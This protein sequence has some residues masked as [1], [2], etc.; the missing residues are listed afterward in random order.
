MSLSA[1]YVARRFEPVREVFER[2]FEEDLEL[3]AGF[4]AWLGDEL[5]VNLTG[6]FA[7][8]ERTQAWTDRTLC[9]VFSTTKP[10]AAL[11]VA[12]LADRGRIDYDAPLARYWPEFGANGKADA[13]VAEALSH[14]AGVPGF[15][16]A[17]DPDLWLDPPALAAA[18]ARVA[19]MWSRGTGSGY[20]PLTWG[21]IAGEL[22]RS[23]DGRS[24]GRVLREE[25]CVP[26]GLDFWIGTPDSE[27]DRAA[28]MMKPRSPTAFGPMNDALKAAFLTPWAAP[29]RG[30]ADWRRTEIPSANGHG[31]AAATARLY[32]A[33]ALRGRIGS[34]RL[35][36]ETGWTA[37][38]RERVAGEDRVLGRKVAF[39]AGVMRNLPL[40]YGPNPESLCHSG[41]GGS[42][43]FGDPAT[44]LAAAYVM[45]R[46]GSD[47]LEDPRRSRLI[48]A[49][50]ACL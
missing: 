38:T 31:T 29:Q 2:H 30:G 39:G 25:I 21:Y 37:L 46:Q 17:I 44:G 49:L 26:L 22:V 23:V 48:A 1:G 35:L 28:Q 4:A 42:G 20:H 36:S 16:D 41:W 33:Y 3:G 7:N 47:L 13:T 14:Q 43:A 19:P 5:V 50:Y 10:V 40:I 8:R 27:H 18:L 45:N 12:W 6:G 24:L 34:V 32:S 15:P 9:P 11:V